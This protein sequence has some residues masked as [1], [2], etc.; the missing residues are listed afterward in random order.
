MK[1]LSLHILDIA[2]NSLKSGAKKVSVTIEEDNAN[3]TLTLTIE[4]DGAGMDEETRNKALSPFFSTK[5]TSKYGL[6]LP[7]LKQA[8]EA[9]GGSMTLVSRPGK[10]TRVAALFHK[11]HI[12]MKPVGNVN[13]TLVALQVCNPDVE[14]EFRYEE[15]D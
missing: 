2:E 14:I 10:G 3:N 6:G 5:K 1:D 15:R 7:L 13:S 11:D 8:C 12:D 4:D 9:T